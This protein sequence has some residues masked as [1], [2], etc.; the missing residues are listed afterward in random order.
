MQSVLIIYC[1][2]CNV[3]QDIFFGAMALDSASAAE[4]L[5]YSHLNVQK[6]VTTATAETFGIPGL[7]FE[8]PDIPLLPTLGFGPQIQAELSGNAAALKV[9]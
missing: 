3:Y 1:F 7:R 5:A 2:I 6:Q 9:R 8:T 4:K